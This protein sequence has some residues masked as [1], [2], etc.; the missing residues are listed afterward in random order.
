MSNWNISFWGGEERE[1]LVY[2]YNPP[3][4]FCPQIDPEICWI[5]WGRGGT[6]SNGKD[7]SDNMAT[8]QFCRNQFSRLLWR[9]NVFCLR[10]RPCAH[11]KGRRGVRGIS[12]PPAIFRILTI[13]MPK[14]P[15]SDP[16]ENPKYTSL[17]H[18]L[19]A[20]KI[21]A[22]PLHKNLMLRPSEAKLAKHSEWT[23]WSAKCV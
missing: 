14:N 11:E 3:K 6:H 22:T 17:T 8:W 15:G 1:E 19:P 2:Q 13:K 9:G 10:K 4:K 20:G 7:I 5:L 16:N 21:L 18:P 12:C 23:N